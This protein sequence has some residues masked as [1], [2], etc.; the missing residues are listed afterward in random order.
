MRTITFAILVTV[1]SAC[2]G[3]GP[4]YASPCHQ[5]TIALAVPPGFGVPFDVLSDGNAPLITG[6]CA[7]GGI[8]VS[9]GTP[10]QAVYRYGYV[11]D[12][13]QWKKV[14]LGGT[15]YGGDWLLGP[16]RVTLSRPAAPNTAVSFTAFTCTRIGGFIQWKCGC[17][18]YYC[19]V[20]MWQLQEFRYAAP[21]PQPEV[22]TPDEDGFFARAGEIR[23]DGSMILLDGHI[24]QTT[25][26]WTRVLPDRV[27][28][29]FTSPVNYAGGR[30]DVRLE[31]L[32]MAHSVPFFYEI[33]F[34]N[35]THGTDGWGETCS[36]PKAAWITG[37]GVYTWT[38]RRP[39]DQWWK[40]S[41][42][43]NWQGGKRK[44]ITV[45]L[46]QLTS[47]I[48]RLKALIR[49]WAAYFNHVP[50]A[51]DAAHGV[52]FIDDDLPLDVHLTIIFTPEGKSFAGFN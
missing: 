15:S 14:E 45:N 24:V 23:S 1:I 9:V 20:P 34:E 29:D 12:G 25:N 32:S 38:D 31:V 49:G 39:P 50:V 22:R 46:Q 11:T 52:I 26:F 13:G 27:P 37:P 7:D 5:F 21:P 51:P 4:A 33:C 6:D 18:N 8:A 48:Q 40:N 16:A 41:R 42:K 35:G 19:D 36:V 44:R 10:G 2:G 30:M 3:A 47:R 43:F 17:R 28:S